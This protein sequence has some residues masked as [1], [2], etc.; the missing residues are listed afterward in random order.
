VRTLA[1]V[2]IFFAQLLA[3]RLL[4]QRTGPLEW[5]GIAL[6]AVGVVVLLNT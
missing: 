5:L 3:G 2:E 4:K 1:L 6:V